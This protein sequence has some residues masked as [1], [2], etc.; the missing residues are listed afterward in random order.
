MK[1]QFLHLFLSIIRTN[2]TIN[3][4][5]MNFTFGQLPWFCHPS[6]QAVAIRDI[7]QLELEN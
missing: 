7:V 2:S 4:V 1:V 5:I 3:S 6:D